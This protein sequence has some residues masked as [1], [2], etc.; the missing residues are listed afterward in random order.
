MGARAFFKLPMMELNG[1]SVSVDD[2][3][4]PELVE[5]KHRLFEAT[6][7]NT[8]IALIEGFLYKR[9]CQPEAHNMRR[10]NAAMQSIYGGERSV[11]ALAQA[12]C[13][14]YKQFKRV[15]ADYVGANPRDYLRV[16]RFQKSLHTLQALPDV[17]F[18]QLAC[19]CGY[20]DQ[21][22]LIKEFR[23]FSG[24]T[25]SEYLSACAPVSDYFS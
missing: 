4:D 25:P 2:L 6:D 14:S 3:S 23:T 7:M 11:E 24:Y 21:A 15:F 17:N 9:L 19:E 12:A 10:I 22:H 13:L 20:F 18:A 5:L 8:C 1:R 16:V